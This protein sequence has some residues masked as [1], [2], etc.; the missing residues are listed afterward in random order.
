MRLMRMAEFRRPSERWKVE[1]WRPNMFV[2]GVVA[3]G[4][5]CEEIGDIWKGEGVASG[6]DLGEM[7]P[8]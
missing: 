3:P 8:G 2:F 4:D 1:N 6:I 5:W 7:S